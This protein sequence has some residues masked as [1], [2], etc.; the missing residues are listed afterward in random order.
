MDKQIVG[1]NIYIYNGR[2]G[3]GSQLKMERLVIISLLVALNIGCSW[4]LD[5]PLTDWLLKLPDLSCKSIIVVAGENY[6]SG[7]EL[8]DNFLRSNE[9]PVMIFESINGLVTNLESL[10]QRLKV[11]QKSCNNLI[12]MDDQV[13]HL[14]RTI[15]LIRS[16]TFIRRTTIVSPNCPLETAADILQTMKDESVTMVTKSSRRYAASAWRIS[17]EIDHFALTSDGAAA[18]RPRRNLM[19]RQLIVAALHLPP[20]SI[21]ETDASS[22]S[23]SSSLVSVSGTEPELVKLLGQSLNF[24]VR[25]VLAAADE[26][27][28]EILDNKTRLTGLIGMLWRREVDLT[29]GAFYL[30]FSRL[31]FID[32]TTTYKTSYDCFLVPAPRPYPLWTA[33]YFPFSP[34]VWTVTALSTLSCIA[35][36]NAVA[37]G[38]A[39]LFPPFS[40]RDAGFRDFGFCA[41]FLIGDVL[42]VRQFREIK[43]L[44]NRAFFFSW[45][46]FAIVVP[47]YYKDEMISHMTLPVSPKPID[48]LTELID[49]PITKTSFGDFFKNSLLSSPDALQRRLGEQIVVIYN[50][51][52]ALAQTESGGS[53]TESTLENLLYLTANELKPNSDGVAR[54]HIVKE[55]MMPTRL[56]FGVQRRSP[57]KPYL[58]KQILRLVEAGFGDHQGNLLPR[59]SSRSSPKRSEIE[60]LPAFSL[61][62]LQGAFF[63]Y[64]V[65]IALATAGFI[66]ENL[67]RICRKSRNSRIQSIITE[68]DQYPSQ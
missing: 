51:S 17:D 12:L 28:G 59:R 57:L 22:N 61:K 42:Q 52:W 10:G 46:V 60:Q 63:L 4:P 68:M 58:D 5:D 40:A 3:D 18:I 48:T 11:G 66:G 55:C 23:N 38:S 36:L 39:S 62:H 45:F 7:G 64:G 32:F 13:D 53:C 21:V 37:R 50:R 8:L 54:V 1:V 27:W 26:M 30:E 14:A 9:R 24:S 56:A 65:G 33:V 2:S 25:Y 35:V 29:I 47:T 41:M 15:D 16:R 67:R 31:P 34:T 19:G 20:F 49:N 44:S 6:W 43:R